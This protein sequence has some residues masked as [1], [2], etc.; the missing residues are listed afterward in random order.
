MRVWVDDL[1]TT[2]RKPNLPHHYP[3]L[4]PIIRPA[5]L[6]NSCRLCVTYISTV[7]S[8]YYGIWVEP[9]VIASFTTWST[10]S[11][12]RVHWY[13]L[14][15]LQS[16]RTINLRICLLPR[17]W[18]NILEQQK[19]ANNRIVEH[20]GW[21][22]GCCSWCLWSRLAKTDIEGSE[23]SHNGS[24]SPLL[25]QYEQYSLGFEPRTL[26]CTIT[27]FESVS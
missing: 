18:S 14:G 17:Q 4:T 26:R 19:A 7:L 9:W 10:N 25:R 13:R 3:T 16:K 24:D 12:R 1:S 2:S 8:E 21:I 15:W 20:R 22:Q 5:C 11:T 27:S 6:A 23:W